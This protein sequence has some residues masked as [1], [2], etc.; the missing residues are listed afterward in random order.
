MNRQNQILIGVLVLQLVLAVVAFWPR[1]SPATATGQALFPGIAADQIRSVRLTDAKGEMIRLTKGDGGWVLPD[2]DDYPAKTEKVTSFLDK[3]AGLKA[4]R[5]ITQTAA[6]HKRLK[7]AE[8]DFNALIEFELSD[9][10]QHRLYMGS[11]A[12]YT[13]AHVRIDGQKEVYLVSGLSSSD[14]SSQAT[15][16]TDSSYFSVTRDDVVSLTLENGN[17]RFEFVKDQ[18]GAWTMSGLA[19]DETLNQAAVTSLLYSVSSVSLQRPLGKEERPEYGLQSPAATVTLKTHSDA[20]GDKTYILRVGAQDAADQTYVVASS[21][22]PYYVRVNSYTV[23]GWIE[24]SRDDFLEVPPTATP[25]PGTT[26]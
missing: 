3:L 17:G 23:S 25:P 1:Q 14:A 22:S 5:L 4:D 12:G 8:G 26:G 21:S 9:G 7:V 18:S 20:E 19:A 16:W 15:T 24:K 13:A 2:A 6:S 11:S 10:S